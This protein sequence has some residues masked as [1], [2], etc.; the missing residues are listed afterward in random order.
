MNVE[1]RGALARRTLLVVVVAAAMFALPRLGLAAGAEGPM[2]ERLSIE[3]AV[4]TP[5]TWTAPQ[6]RAWPAEQ[7]TRVVLPRKVDGQDATSEV[8]GVR[9]TTL[10]E[11]AALAEADHNTWKHTVVVATAT[12]GYQVVFS[13]PELFDTEVGAGVL[14]IV[15]RDGQPLDDREGHIALVSARDTR[16]GPRNVHWLTRI[17]VRVLH[18]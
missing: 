7:S 17:D 12:D 2:S 14:V 3:G 5:M 11:R 13:W 15:E 1:S 10:L 18:D 8:R 16:A 6:L 4:R 9:L